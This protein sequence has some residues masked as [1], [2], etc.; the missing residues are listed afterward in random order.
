MTAYDQNPFQGKDSDRYE[1]WEMLVRRDIDAFLSCDWA[2]TEPDFIREGFFGIDGEK[3]PDPDNW[4]INFS[5][6]G[7]YRDEW[8]RQAEETVGSVDEKNAREALFNAVDLTYI[9]IVGECAVA[10]KKFDGYFPLA[11]GGRDRMNWQTLYVCRKVQGVWKIASFVGYLK[12]KE[13]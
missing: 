4:R 9:D 2:A 1:I 7:V 3:D 12:Y 5:N 6:L 10:H 11:N 13:A 8:L